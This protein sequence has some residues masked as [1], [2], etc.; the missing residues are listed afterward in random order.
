MPENIFITGASKGIGLGLA[1]RFYKEG[2]QVGICA[3]GEEA[4]GLAS[5]RMPGVKTYICD[6]AD[7]DQ[8]L[9]LAKRVQEE[10]GT[11]EVLVNNG[12]V[13]VPG[14]V[15]D[16][17]MHVFER[18]MNINLYSAFYLT[19]FLLPQMKERK[20]GM[21]VNMCSVASLH[22]YPNGGIY[23]T[24]KFALLGFSKSLRE[25]LKES[26]I[27]VISVLPGAVYTASWEG[28]D[29]PEDRFMPVE[30]IA[31]MIWSAYNLS[32]RT[33]VEELIIRPALGDI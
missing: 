3:R 10:M 9:Q 16:A 17:P 24:S 29:L 1:E 20:R 12:G 19:S 26:G 5:E 31:E 32:D 15:H 8:V 2:F 28:V 27:R 18:V 23:S 30:D 4:L 25:E 13:F 6:L 7:K 11:I 33:V 14:S 21:I 22:A